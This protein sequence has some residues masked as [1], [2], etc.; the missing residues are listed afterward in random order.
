MIS[1]SSDYAPMSLL[2][3]NAFYLWRMRCV[4]KREEPVHQDNQ[5]KIVRDL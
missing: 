1:P 5:D 3:H 2:T 4:Q